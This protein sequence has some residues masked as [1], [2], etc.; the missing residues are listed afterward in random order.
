ME[1][2]P[3]FV[4]IGVIGVAFGCSGNGNG[5]SGRVTEAYSAAFSDGDGQHAAGRIE[6]VVSA[7]YDC[8]GQNRDSYL[9]SFSRRAGH[10]YQTSTR[11]TAGSIA[12]DGEGVAYLP[13]T[14]QQEVLVPAAASGFAFDASIQRE[15]I[16]HLFLEDPRGRA[17]VVCDRTASRRSVVSGGPQK[18]LPNL[19]EVEL[20]VPRVDRP[21]AGTFLA[22]ERVTVDVTTNLPRLAADL[23]ALGFV[24]LDWMPED[25]PTVW[26]DAEELRTFAP[27]SGRVATISDL[28]LPG[29]A[30]PGQDSVTLAASVLTVSKGQLVSDAVAFYAVALDLVYDEEE[31]E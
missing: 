7:G 16:R 14:I 3:R 2:F 20:V 13:L 10:A 31:L 5:I 11:V 26:Q 23:G 12:H 4:L 18:L 17:A 28:S 29:P 8:L 22:G 19:L 1:Y 15:E 24:Q 6:G 30:V 21:A 27:L 25:G 9:E